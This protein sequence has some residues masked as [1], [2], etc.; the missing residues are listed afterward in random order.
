MRCC[1]NCPSVL[2]PCRREINRRRH[3]MDSRPPNVCRCHRRNTHSHYCTE[4]WSKLLIQ[5]EGLA[6][7][8]SPS[9]CG[10]QSLRT[11]LHLLSEL[12]A[13]GGGERIWAFEG[14]L[15][16]SCQVQWCW[17]PTNV[18]HY[19][20]LLHPSQRMW[21]QEGEL[22]SGTLV[23]LASQRQRLTQKACMHHRQA[24]H[25]ESERP[26]WPSCPSGHRN[27]P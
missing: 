14:S 24:T 12:S 4:G 15:E 18:E 3:W 21:N 16:M 2:L 1:W 6:F 22:S 10:P 5:Q 17:H 20:G 11:T 7:P 26:L 25:S 23:V 13:N 8:C 9:D 19:F 27:D